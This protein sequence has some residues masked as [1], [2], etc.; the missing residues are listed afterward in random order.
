MHAFITG[1]AKKVLK[2]ITNL[3]DM[4]EATAGIYKK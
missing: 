3:L 4:L 2:G 1:S